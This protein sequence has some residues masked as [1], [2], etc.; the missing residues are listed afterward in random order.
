MNLIA[1]MQSNSMDEFLTFFAT[2]DDFINSVITIILTIL[3]IYFPIWIFISIYKNRDD[4]GNR[5]FL[6]EFGWLFEDLR[7]T[8]L[9]VA[10]YQLFFILRRLYYAF[11]LTFFPTNPI[12][13]VLSFVMISVV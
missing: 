1:F 10:Y 3:I 11:I 8:E 2:R 7:M 9:S 13:H 6:N 4:L 5:E 12:L